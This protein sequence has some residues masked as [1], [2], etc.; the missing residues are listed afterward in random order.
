MCKEGFARAIWQL[1]ASWR[2]W[3]ARHTRLADRRP[4]KTVGRGC[5]KLQLDEACTGRLAVECDTLRVAP[6]STDLSLHPPERG[7]DVEHAPVAGRRARRRIALKRHPP[8]G[9][10]PIVEI[11]GDNVVEPR[12][13]RPGPREYGLRIIRDGLDPSDSVIING[14]VRA[15]PGATVTPEPGQITPAD[16][17]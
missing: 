5:H 14:M 9:P 13:V 6:E 4:E 7:L 10:R 2:E 12:V 15:R 8:D 1:D 3:L 16:Q 17:P 11:D